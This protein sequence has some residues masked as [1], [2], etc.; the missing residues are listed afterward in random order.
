MKARPVIVAAF[1][2]AELLIVPAAVRAHAFLD[3]SDPAVGSTVPA[4][5]AVNPFVVH[6]TSRAGL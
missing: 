6:T 1:V 3:H 2:L 5:P 4:S